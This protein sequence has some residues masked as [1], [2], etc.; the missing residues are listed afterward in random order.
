MERKEEIRQKAL[1]HMEGLEVY[2]LPLEEQFEELRNLLSDLE[3]SII[4]L[5]LLGITQTYESIMEDKM[6]MYEAQIQAFR[7]L[8]RYLNQH[9]I[10]PNKQEVITRRGPVPQLEEVEDAEEE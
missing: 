4:I 6:I 2:Y 9:V 3:D 5:P 1:E 8:Y 7:A 10:G